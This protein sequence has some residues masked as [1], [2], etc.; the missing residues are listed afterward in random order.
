MTKQSRTKFLLF[1]MSVV[2]S[3]ALAFF[4]CSAAFAETPAPESADAVFSHAMTIYFRGES[5]PGLK[6][7]EE[8]IANHPEH[9]LSYSG[10]AFVEAM[11]QID[12]LYNGSPDRARELV[13]KARTVG[14]DNKWNYMAPAI[15]AVARYMRG[16]MAAILD[17]EKEAKRGLKVDPKAGELH[18]LLWFIN[19]F[20]KGDRAAAAREYSAAV[21]GMQFIN[22]HYLFFFSESFLGDCA[23]A[24]PEAVLAVKEL[25]EAKSVYLEFEHPD[26]GDV[27]KIASAGCLMWKALKNE[28]TGGKIEE[29]EKLLRAA[30]N[31]TPG[32]VI[33]ADKLADILA[34]S[35]RAAEAE[36][37]LSDNYKNNSEN[38][39]A[40]LALAHFYAYPAPDDAKLKQVLENFPPIK[41]THYE[42]SY[43]SRFED[44][45]KKV[46]VTPK[47][48]N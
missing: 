17:V 4:A 10:L 25:P 33:A 40:A 21:S 1:S 3:L 38:A 2:A 31:E 8:N 34:G 19:K 20:I 28:K 26:G 37:L 47:S 6:L 7:L 13:A 9:T 24:V 18:F 35:G 43:R 44:L 46:G 14:P 41:K 48:Q 15:N 32:F 12:P 22:P 42:P 27:E 36:Q 23:A 29:R 30:L 45:C 11:G 39:G 5:I 16:D